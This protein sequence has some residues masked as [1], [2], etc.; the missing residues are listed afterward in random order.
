VF[1][2][3][4]AF[5]FTATTNNKKEPTGCCNG[6][7]D[8]IDS[9]NKE[10]QIESALEK[11]RSRSLAMHHSH[12]LQY[13]VGVMYE[14]LTRLQFNK[15]ENDVLSICLFDDDTGDM[16]S[17]AT[18][19]G[20]AVPFCLTTRNNDY[21]IYTNIWKARANGEDF[22]SKVY[23]QEEKNAF[24]GYLFAQN[25]YAQ[26]PQKDKDDVM[27][28]EGYAYEIAIAKHACIMYLNFHGMLTLSGEQKEILKRFVNVFEQAY[29]RFIDLQKAEAQ[30]REAQ[31][32]A[33]L[34]RVRSRS[35]AMQKSE[36]LREVIQLVLDQ[37]LGLHF[38]IDSASFTVD[39]NESNEFRVWLAAPGQQYAA[40]IDV[41]YLD[42]PIFNRTLEA[43]EKG[44]T[45]YTLQLT[46]E[47]KNRFF[48]HFF[49]YAPT[50]E[51]RRKMLYSSAGYALSAVL[52]KSVML[53]IYNYSAVPYS[54]EQNATLARF[55]KAFEQ[56]YTRFLDLQKAEA[57]AREAQ[58]EAAL[59]RVRSR[60][61]GMQ[62]SEELR[63]V[64]QVILDQLL[65]LQFSIDSASF[66]V[67]LNESDDLRNWVAAP[68]Q[69]YAT[70]IDLPYIDHPIFRHFAEAKKRGEHFFTLT[71]TKEEKDRFFNHFFKYAPVTADRRKV[72][73]NSDG[74]SQASVLMK[75]VALTIHNYSAIPY[76]EEQNKTL[77]RFG[78]AFEQTYTR[79]LDLQKAEAQAREAQIEAALERVRSRSMGMQKSEELREVIQVIFDQ[80]Y[81]LHINLDF[82][83]F[84]VEID[85]TNDLRNWV[86][87]PLS[88]YA[89]RIDVPYID[90]PLFNRLIEA[91]EKGEDFIILQLNKEEK[92]RFFDHYFKFA[93]TT[94]ERKSYVYK[95]KSWV[96]SIVVMRS[97]TLTMANYSGIPFTD[98]ENKT[99][100]RF[101][102][103]FE[104]TYTRFLD[105]QKAEAAAREAV[106]QASIDRVRAEIASMRTTKDLDRII[107]L[108][109]NELT[110]LH[111]PFIRCGVFIVNED[112]QQTQVYLSTPEGKAIA[113]FQLPFNSDGFY[114]NMLEHW[115]HNQIFKDHWDAAA[116][117]AWT[118]SLVEGGAIQPDERYSN[119]QPPDNL[120]LHF[121]PFMQGMLYVGNTDPLSADELSLIE[122]L[123]DAFSTAYARYEDFSKLEMAKQQIETTLTEL[124][125]TQSQLIQKEKMASL[126]ELT[127]GIAHEIQNPLNFVNNFSEVS[128]ELVEELKG[129]RAK[130]N[131]ERDEELET[132]ILNDLSQNLVKINHHGKRA[133]AI[134]KGMLEHSRT[135]KGEKQL[136]DLN[137]LAD[138][139]L[140]L[141]YHGLRAKD[142][143]FN[144][145]VKTDFDESIGKIEV[146]AQDIGRVLLNLYN[147]AFHA[148]STRQK[149][150]GEGFKPIVKVQTKKVD[151]R[152]EVIVSD[153]GIGMPD[154]VVSKIFQPFFTTKPT[155]QGT[156]LGLSLS[157]DI[158]KAHG[159]EIKVQSREGEGSEFII[160]L[161]VSHHI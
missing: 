100:V 114:K 70:R 12:E 66:A 135:S 4:S 87:S 136:T 108:I 115:R 78:K 120:Y 74:W 160:K 97:L 132:A 153:S 159:G 130:V 59:E 80:L 29:T 50:T 26:L 13:V 102:K 1:F 24:W 137:A 144:A 125:S 58:I 62:K 64:I 40:R 19:T 11:V 6:K 36:E 149:S 124:K 27:Q 129:E 22:L 133:D 35:M 67:E 31:I 93:A 156:G 119:E 2:Y 96:Q 10:L 157:Y 89:T 107:P 14:Q 103:A 55:G 5:S 20:G 140:R 63:E 138:E 122:S 92:D 134:V 45:F 54:A 148:V 8:E 47:E 28:G 161:P 83:S 95:S 43:K 16:L 117:S 30:A 18:G 145:T 75:T 143:D 48:D 128:T 88:Q 131:G 116:F 41:P 33:A 52:M 53:T 109:W 38:P 106:K 113:A 57:Q 37:L 101:G 123:A 72:L 68:G 112:A 158:I 98:E 71:C 139:Y 7:K 42:H 56:T 90:H 21:A 118:H 121:V 151:S 150:E 23:S 61:M 51:E 82:A 155:G 105:L 60:S 65:T 39:F 49:K 154:K 94:E 86:A 110:I 126:G 9:K 127:A 146:V 81:S 79:F 99:L 141:A 147:N 104:Q 91:K 77:V 32:E 34:E 73:Y 76:S 85:K 25:N 44:E 15:T 3:S 142:K 111:I 69:Q 17:W 46:K 84:A 152:V